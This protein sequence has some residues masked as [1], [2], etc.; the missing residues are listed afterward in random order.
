MIHWRVPSWCYSRTFRDDTRAFIWNEASSP[1]KRLGQ[2][3]AYL[4]TNHVQ[5]AKRRAGSCGK[6]SCRMFIVYGCHFRSNFVILL[7]VVFESP[8]GVRQALIRGS[9]WSASWTVLMLFTNLEARRL[10]ECPVF[11]FWLVQCVAKFLK[12]VLVHGGCRSGNLSSKRSITRCGLPVELYSNTL[13][14][15]CSNVH[16]T[17]TML[18]WDL[19]VCDFEYLTNKVCSKAFLLIHLGFLDQLV[20]V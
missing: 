20:M 4:S 2:K 6:S 17:P 11:L 7:N 8:V 15:H 5:N 1:M 12:I 3:W 13:N 18:C 16:C 14:V 9:R 10:P 19:A